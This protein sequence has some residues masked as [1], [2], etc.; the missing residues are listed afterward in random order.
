MVRR[1]A[2]W[3]RQHLP[4]DSGKEIDFFKL[5]CHRVYSQ[6]LNENLHINK[7]LTLKSSNYYYFFQNHMLEEAMETVINLYLVA[8]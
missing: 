5:I 4:D 7:I 3:K 6:V 8:K 2:D 1:K